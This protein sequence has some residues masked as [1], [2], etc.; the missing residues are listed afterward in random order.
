MK[1]WKFGDFLNRSE[2]RIGSPDARMVPI[3]AIHSWRS[4]PMNQNNLN[5]DG[6]EFENDCFS[7]NLVMTV[8]AGLNPA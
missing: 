7:V 4:Q 3:L 8:D 2:S 1:A 6:Q 5:S